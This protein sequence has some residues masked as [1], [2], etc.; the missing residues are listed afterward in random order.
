MNKESIDLKPT[1]L[2]GILGRESM[3]ILADVVGR[4][5]WQEYRNQYEKASRLEIVSE[6]PIQIDF[7]LNASC[8]L[9]CPMCPNSA[10]S[11]KDRN[12]EEWFKFEDFKKIIDLGVKRGLKAIKL[13]YINE[14]LIRKDITKFISYAKEKGVLDIYFSTNGLLLNNEFAIELI[15][16]G[17]TRIQVS[18]DAYTPETYDLIRPGGDLKKVVENVE[19]LLQK[20]KELGSI[21]PLVRVNFVRTELN[22]HEL[23]SFVN[24][25]KNKVEMIGVQEMIKPPESSQDI[26]STTTKN[27]RKIGFQCSM[28][29][30]Q[31]VLNNSGYIL[32]CCTFYGEQ[33]RMGNIKNDD[34][35]DMWTSEKMKKLRDIHKNGNY[36]EIEVCKN[37][38]EGAVHDAD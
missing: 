8:N 34:I 26:K 36:F 24:Y 3:D 30:K 28:P 5:K 29:F 27:K 19:L 1:E 35:V 20:R 12:K 25:W 9:K 13:N 32:P 21:T 11:S 38:V 33:L 18:I 2:T 23:E 14:P 16:S 6:F 22:E 37:C 17:L 4:D 15:D 7:E 10:E 31:L